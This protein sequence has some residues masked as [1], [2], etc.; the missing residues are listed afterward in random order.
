MSASDNSLTSASTPNITVNDDKPMTKS[1]SN[2]NISDGSSNKNPVADE[3]DHN[4]THN[5][6]LSSSNQ[7]EL[8]AKVK[9]EYKNDSSF[10]SQR[11]ANSALKQTRN[12]VLLLNVVTN[13]V[14]KNICTSTLHAIVQAQ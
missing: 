2:G 1:A 3:P 8:F 4:E 12:K 9:T 13:Y 14:A 10:T 11:E 7:T 6:K 5:T